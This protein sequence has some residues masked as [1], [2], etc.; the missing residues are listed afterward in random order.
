MEEA[1][2]HNRENFGP[3]IL[4][5]ETHDMCELTESLRPEMRLTMLSEDRSLL[6]PW[7]R[8]A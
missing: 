2:F 8:T 5:H 3:S 4:L 6:F 1:S 7:P